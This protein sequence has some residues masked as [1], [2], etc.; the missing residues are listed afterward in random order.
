MHERNS[1][2]TLTFDDA[3]LPL[4]GSISKRDLQLFLKRLRKGT[5]GA[6]RFFGVGEYGEESGRPHYHCLLFGRDFDDRR[7]FTTRNGVS[8]FTSEELA[9]FWKFGHSTVGDLT[10]QS[11]AYC[12]RYVLKKITGD[13][14]NEHYKY[15]DKETG[16]VFDREPEFALMSNGGR[17]RTGGIGAGWFNA[18]RN[19]VFPDDFVVMKGRRVKTPAY[20]DVLLEKQIHGPVQPGKSRSF[21]RERRRVA[22]EARGDETSPRRLRVREKVFKARLSQLKRGL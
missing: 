18:Y 14:A 19:D 22:A 10:F 6:V 20:Y 5:S 21:F 7:L 15:T 12:A 2:V 9:G 4:N 8:V 17:N 13:P 16:E 11:A 3:N 1:F